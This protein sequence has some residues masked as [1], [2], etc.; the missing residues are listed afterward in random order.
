MHLLLPSTILLAMLGLANAAAG[1]APTAG[2]RY[3]WPVVEVKDGD[4]L[5]VALPGLPDAL[6]PVAIRI[7]GIDAP[8]SGG[9]GRCPF[10]RALA[11]RATR[12]TTDA[13]AYAVRIEFSNPAWDKYGGRIDADVWVDGRLLSQQ[14]IAA[15]LA[16][17][18]DGGK[19]RGWC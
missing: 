3:V 16:R 8:E 14:L 1:P 13:V 2:A 18:Y 9:R 5:S 19:R 12:F 10:E 4:T 15:G 11:Q 17:I 6:N 7:R